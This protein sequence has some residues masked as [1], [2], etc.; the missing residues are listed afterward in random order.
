MPF[1]QYWRQ[2]YV[3]RINLTPYAT[4]PM[5]NST[6]LTIKKCFQNQWDITAGR[7]LCFAHIQLEFDPWDSILSSKPAMS[8]PRAQVRHKPCTP[9]DVGHQLKQIKHVSNILLSLPSPVLPKIPP[10]V[11]Q[12][13]LSNRIWFLVPLLYWPVAFMYLVSSHPNT[14]LSLIQFKWYS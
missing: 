1:I 4:E 7:V 13:S 5:L 12:Y 2:F 9:L 6:V 11:I 8:D 3:V 10:Y 14:H